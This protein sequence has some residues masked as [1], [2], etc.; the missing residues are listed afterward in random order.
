MNTMSDPFDSTV[1]PPRLPRLLCLHGGGSSATIFKI[2]TIRLAHYL[3]KHFHLVYLD[4]PYPSPA[5]PGILPVFESVPPYFRWN[6]QKEDDDPERVKTAIRKIM[7]EEGDGQPFVGIMGFSQ[8]AMISAGI[9]YE[10]YQRGGGLAGEDQKFKFGV[11]LVPG[12][13]PISLDSRYT[14]LGD[15]Y[16]YGSTYGDDRY[17]NTIGVSSV[18]MHGRSDPVLPNSRAL[19]KCFKDGSDKDAPLDGDGQKIQKTVLEFDVGHHMP[20]PGSAD[21]KI[22]ADAI[23]RTHYGADWKPDDGT[24]ID[25]E[26]TKNRKLEQQ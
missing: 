26:L 16:C 14:A 3:R 15:P 23:L 9:L 12:F 21:T 19:G 6:P 7:I 18:H 4:G 20:T 5:G 24:T 1:A 2:Q 8:G 22:L 11:F 25:Q 10:Q 17:W 13:P